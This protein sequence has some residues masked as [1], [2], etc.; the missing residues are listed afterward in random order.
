MSNMNFLS[1]SFKEPLSKKVSPDYTS[2]CEEK[3]ELEKPVVENTF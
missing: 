1:F 2:F 3:S